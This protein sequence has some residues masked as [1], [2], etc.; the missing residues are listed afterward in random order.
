MA[1]HNPEEHAAAMV[2]IRRLPRN[3]FLVTLLAP[4]LGLSVYFRHAPFAQTFLTVHRG[5]WCQIEDRLPYGQKTH[6]RV[7]LE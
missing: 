1:Q 5:R 2:R 6:T 7:N 3:E 4:Q